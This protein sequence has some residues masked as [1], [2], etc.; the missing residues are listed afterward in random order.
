MS[1]RFTFR[2]LDQMTA[3]L[4]VLAMRTV[5]PARNLNSVLW[6]VARLF[7]DRKTVSLILG[8]QTV[9]SK[10]NAQKRDAKATAEWSQPSTDLVCY[11]VYRT[12]TDG[13]PKM[14]ANNRNAHFVTYM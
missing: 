12:L 5:D 2:P 3:R 6:P 7:T 14:E 8:K 11:K 13:G 4:T 1:D 10:S 9:K